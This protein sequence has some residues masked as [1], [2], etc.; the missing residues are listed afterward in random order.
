MLLKI[1]IIRHIDTLYDNAS[2]YYSYHVSYMKGLKRKCRWH[3]H[4]ST[5]LYHHYLNVST[6]SIAVICFSCCNGNI[7]FSMK[8]S[9]TVLPL[10]QLYACWKGQS[11]LSIML[12]NS[13]TIDTIFTLHQTIVIRR[14]DQIIHEKEIIYIVIVTIK[15]MIKLIFVY[16]SICH[17]PK[18]LYIV[19]L[20]RLY[21]LYMIVLH[22]LYEKKTLLWILVLRLYMQHNLDT[23]R[24]TFKDLIDHVSLLNNL[25]LG[26]TTILHCII[27]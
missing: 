5:N 13:I 19:A 1:S 27:V 14:W 16:A 7:L 4:N 24:E 22:H 20:Y 15:K 2:L 11:V 3:N 26:Y 8:G 21:L 17:F 25:R 23:P 12:L 6:L 18:D 9:T 10:I